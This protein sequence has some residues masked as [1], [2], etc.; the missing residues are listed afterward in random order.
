MRILGERESVW[1]IL[2]FVDN[3]HKTGRQHGWH[4]HFSAP[5]TSVVCLDVLECTHRGIDVMVHLNKLVVQG[6]QMQGLWKAL[7]IP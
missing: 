2:F 5:K 6:Q 4:I 7:N 1:S 3:T